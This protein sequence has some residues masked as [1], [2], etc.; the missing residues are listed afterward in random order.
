MLGFIIS[1]AM[2]YFVVSFLN[3]FWDSEKLATPSG[4]LQVMIVATVFSIG[5]GWLVDK[6]DGDSESAQ[7]KMS[8]EEIIQTGDPLKIAKLIVGIN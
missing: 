4:K 7:S 1:S 6:I 8:F 3:R 5:T 2:F